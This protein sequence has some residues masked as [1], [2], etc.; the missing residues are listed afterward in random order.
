MDNARRPDDSTGDTFR[1]T[2]QSLF[3]FSIAAWSLLVTTLIVGGQPWSALCLLALVIQ[4]LADR[5]VVS[6]A[7]IIPG[8]LWL[9]LFRITGNRE[10]FFPYAMYLATHVSLLLCRRSFWLGSLGGMLVVAVFLVVRYLQYATWRVLA[11][12]FGVAAAILALAL[13]A[14]PASPRNLYTHILTA[15]VASLLAY[16]GLSI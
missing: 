9:I 8:L 1:S 13:V 3:V 10:L 14:Y 11:V 4:S 5:R 6:L 7:I 12:E 15:G 2:A 16:A